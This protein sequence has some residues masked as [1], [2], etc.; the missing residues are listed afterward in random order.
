VPLVAELGGHLLPAGRLREGADLGQV[1]AHRLLDVDVLAEPD[2]AH[3]GGRVVV[4]GRG[5]EDGVELLAHLVVHLPEVGVGPGL[6][7]LPLGLLHRPRHRLVVHVHEGHD[8]PALE[9][10]VEVRHAAAAHADAGDPEPLAGASCPRKRG[11]PTGRPCPGA[12]R[13]A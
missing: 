13:G 8:L 9:G 4:V 5:H 6:V 2:R 11:Q 7:A 12:S 1:V 10:L 3:H